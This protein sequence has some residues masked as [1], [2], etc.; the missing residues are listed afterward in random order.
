MS[1]PARLKSG[2]LTQ[3][4]IRE[5]DEMSTEDAPLKPPVHPRPGVVTTLG[6]CN[7]VFS[8][9]TGFCIFGSTAWIDLASS[10]QAAPE[11]P[12]QGRGQGQANPARRPAG[13]MVAFNPFMGMDDP[14]FLRFSYVENGTSLITNGLMFA[15]GIGLLNLRRWGARWWTYLAW[16][17]IVLAVLL[18]GYYI[19]GVAPVFS[20]SMAKNVVAMIQ[21][22]GRPAGAGCRRSADLTRIYSIMNLIVAV[23]TMLI[24]SIYPAISLW[25]LS[26]PGVKAAIVDKPATEPELP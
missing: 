26:R 1:S 3:N 8:V 23:G 7:I 6:I 15:T 13:P 17:K 12:G 20:E 24:A 11:G 25:L 19:V 2:L 21:Q 9:L 4:G 10:D 22:S 5:T 14:N 16:A 18:W